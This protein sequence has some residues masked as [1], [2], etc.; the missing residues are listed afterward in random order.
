M[1][2]YPKMQISHQI[3]REKNVFKI[4]SRYSKNN[5]GKKTKMG[6][7]AKAYLLK[8]L[9]FIK[10]GTIIPESDMYMYR[11]HTHLKTA[12]HANKMC[13]FWVGEA[14]GKIKMY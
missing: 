14:R 3:L 13:C 10:L 7:K 11:L 12:N 5:K 1:F 6:E 9:L 4:F 8:L 2:N